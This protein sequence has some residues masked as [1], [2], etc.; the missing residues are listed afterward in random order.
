[1]KLELI[2]AKV[3]KFFTFVLFMFMVLVYFGFLLLLPLDI[4]TQLTR[5]FSAIG[6]P[7]VI[8]AALGIGAVGY[9]GYQIYRMPRL[10]GLVVDIGMELIAFGQA[11]LRRF[12]PLIED[13]KPVATNNASAA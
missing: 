1:M 7:T 8:A 13:S 4:L 2:L 11:Q 3:L 9:L 6:F 5:I 10:Y 12:D